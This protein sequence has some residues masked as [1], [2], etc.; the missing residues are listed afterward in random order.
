MGLRVALG[1]A[2]N[3]LVTCMCLQAVIHFAGLKAVGESVSEPMLYY[4]NNL[5]GTA[6]LIEAMAEAGCK[7]MVFSS[8]CT[9]YGNPQVSLPLLPLTICL[10]LRGHLLPFPIEASN[11]IEAEAG[12]K[13]W[14]IP[15]LAPPTG[16]LPLRISIRSF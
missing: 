3:R 11:L 7:R 2:C 8:S 9:V 16:L 10:P 1:V 12:C 15:V 13:P 5:V 6:N 14:S 4:N